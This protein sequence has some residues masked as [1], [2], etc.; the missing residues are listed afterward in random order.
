MYRSRDGGE[1]WT[2]VDSGINNP[3]IYGMALS[4][5]E[6]KTVLVSTPREIFASQDERET[7]QSL[8]VTSPS[9]CPTA[10]G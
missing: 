2:H 10:G 1:T 3:G 8:A 7:F 9:R 5:G 4:L 6:Q